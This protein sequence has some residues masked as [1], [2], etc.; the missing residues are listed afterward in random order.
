MKIKQYPADSKLIKIPW[1]LKEN[2]LGDPENFMR[3]IAC[4]STESISP[5]F[6][7]KDKVMSLIEASE[8]IYNPFDDNTGK[9]KEDFIPS[10]SDTFHRYLHVDLGLTR[11]ACGI[12][13]CH[14]PYFVPRSL[15]TLE[16]GVQR[17]RNINLPFVRFDFVGRIKADR[18]E[19]IILSQIREI[20]YDISRR[21]FFINLM[22]YDGFQSVESIQILRSQGYRVSRLSIDRTATRLIIDKHYE[23][24][25]GVKRESTDGQNTAAIQSL[26]DALYDDRLAVPFHPYVEKEL[27]GAEIDYKKNKVDHNSRGTIDV[28]HSMSGSCYNLVN[29]EHELIET[30]SDDEYDRDYADD[31]YGD[32]L[33]DNY[34]LDVEYD[35][36]E[37]WDTF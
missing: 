19:E 32:S 7:R 22:S 21:G 25:N 18:G 4:I 35:E 9:L 23:K 27:K 1:T 12:S 30:H 16:E 37:G 13:M 28:L 36:D 26:K 15:L 5:F 29:N 33:N 8:K 20:I 11:D 24:N 10:T 3:D 17:R 14:A 34:E 2:F 6:K 31:F